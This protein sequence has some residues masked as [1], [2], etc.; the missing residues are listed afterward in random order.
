MKV[1]SLYKI[2]YLFYF[3]F[4]CERCR[5][6]I[7]SPVCRRRWC[8]GSFL[9]R[10][11]LDTPHACHL[12]TH[13]CRFLFIF[14]CLPF[15]NFVSDICLTSFMLPL[16]SSS[17]CWGEYVSAVGTKIGP[18][19]SH[20]TWQGVQRTGQDIDVSVLVDVL[21]P[22]C[23]RVAGFRQ[24]HFHLLQFLERKNTHTLLINV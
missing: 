13:L 8:I 19:V 11:E 9:W 6:L 3:V 12:H 4:V 20:A 18:S 24:Q 22:L 23:L 2:F 17:W 16:I 14:L 5:D 10:D 1:I 21:L 7:N 15:F